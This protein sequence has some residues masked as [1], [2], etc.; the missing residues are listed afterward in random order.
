MARKKQKVYKKEPGI[1]KVFKQ[2]VSVKSLSKNLRL[3]SR[4]KAI[5]PGKRMSKNNKVY[6]EKRHNRSD[7][8]NEKYPYL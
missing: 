1:L 8:S 7:A 5:K 4:I 3:D 6:Y 2:N